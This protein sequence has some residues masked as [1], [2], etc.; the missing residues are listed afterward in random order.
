MAAIEH[1]P[2]EPSTRTQPPAFAGL[3]VPGFQHGNET[4]FP[5][6][7]NVQWEW[8]A[9]AVRTGAAPFL[10]PGW[11]EAWWRAFGQDEP[12]L[13]MLRKEGRLAALA[14]MVRRPKRLEGAVN[15]HTPAFGLLA[16]SRA[17]ALALAGDLFRDEPTH[18]SITHLEPEGESL[19]ACQEAAEEAGYRVVVSP[20]QR[21]M[22]LQLKQDWSDYQ[23][24]RGRNLLR[25]L[26]RSRRQL[27]KQGKLAVETI[28]DAEHLETRLPEAY[29]VEAA[30]WKGA[31][32]TAIQSHPRTRRFYTALAYW[33]AERGALR[34]YIMRVD[35]RPIAMYYALQMNGISHLLKGGYDPA[36]GRYSPGKLLLQEVIESCFA[37]GVSRVE[38]HGG[39][40][41]YKLEW[42]SAAREYQR[43][44]AF[45]PTVAGQLAW[46]AYTYSRP[47]TD[48]LRQGLGFE[49]RD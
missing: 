15:V 18:V 5:P 21:S 10:H 39:T 33:A 19:R 38:F 44:E 8:E 25:N 36:F 1:G 4:R 35:G 7:P 32:G 40:E 16:E 48:R 30:S 14:P 13:Y 37:N 3:P 20:F 11:A 17:A 31:T 43:L 23:R 42:A 47:V 12:A 22:H 45:A 34:L 28:R 26:R 6:P 9:L 27:Q 24:E 2:R 41:A 46:A 49:N 29:C